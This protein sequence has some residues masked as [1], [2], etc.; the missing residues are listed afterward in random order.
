MA[1]DVAEGRVVRIR[2]DIVDVRFSGR[3]P[4]VQEFLDAEGLP[5]EVTTLLGPGAVRC[6]ALAPDA[7]A[8]VDLGFIRL[9]TTIV[10]RLVV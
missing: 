8:I 6:I 3:T 7:T 2:G 5:L 10:N 1:G 4:G 9:N